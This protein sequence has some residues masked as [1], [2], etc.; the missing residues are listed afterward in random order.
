MDS[1]II[2]DKLDYYFEGKS[3]LEDEQLLMEYF[4]SGEIDEQFAPYNF[5]FV[6]LCELK[7]INSNYTYEVPVLKSHK[8]KIWA[9][10]GSIA[11]TLLIGLI[12]I[13]FTNQRYSIKD[14][15]DDPEMAY[16]VAIQTLEYVAIQYQKGINQLEPVQKINQAIQ[17]FNKGM[18]T[19]SEGFDKINF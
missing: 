14:T 6:G 16:T 3:S 18:K 11:A 8:K 13:H 17:P 2:K 5:F 19:L 10:I 12:I 9:T 1:K 4:N 7:K 15:Y